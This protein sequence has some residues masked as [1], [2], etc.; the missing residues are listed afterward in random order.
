MAY[1]WLLSFLLL[2]LRFIGMHLQTSNDIY[3]YSAVVSLA[4]AVSPK[5]TMAFQ[6]ISHG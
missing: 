4:L 6:S 2:L 1:F 3:I 5:Q